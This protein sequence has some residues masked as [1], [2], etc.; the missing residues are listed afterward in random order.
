MQSKVQI[1]QMV[2]PDAKV[3]PSLIMQLRIIY[4]QCALCKDLKCIAEHFP[5]GKLLFCH[6]ENKY[7]GF[8]SKRNS[9]LSMTDL[10]AQMVK[11][12]REWSYMA[13]HSLSLHFVL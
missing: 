6:L 12:R 1:V 4:P 9:A 11:N 3:I 10:I 2:L 13:M 8:S 7:P 5:L